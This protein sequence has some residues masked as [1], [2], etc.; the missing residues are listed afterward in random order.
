ML[1]IASRKLFSAARYAASNSGADISTRTE[2]DKTQF[3]GTELLGKTLAVIGV[4]H[5][6]AL[7]AHAAS[8]L[9][10]RVIGYDP[11]LSADDAWHIPTSTVRA[12]TL[13]EALAHADYVT[14]HVPKN[15]ATTNMLSDRELAQMKRGAI[16]LNFARGGIVNNDAVLAALD[17]GQIQRYMTDFGA[18]E[19]LNRPDVLITPHLGGSTAQAEENG[20]VQ[21]AETMMSF[22]E[23]G[24]VRNSINLPTL[25]VPFNTANR[26]TIMHQ[27]IPNMV[28]QIAT[29]LAASGVNIEGMS[30][31]AKGKVAYTI[32]DTKRMADAVVTTVLA[33]I[34]GIAAVYRGRLI[35]R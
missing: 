34:N 21:G 19:L 2:H 4:G 18:D 27:N 20:A 6:G 35:A 30:N 26:L 31:A 5:V 17:A 3:N 23:T 33:Q 32:V 15:A 16:L 7:V 28:G 22:L 13:E 14:V 10:M 29:I 24:N 25:Q 9:G 1:I 12:A 11:Y 8:D